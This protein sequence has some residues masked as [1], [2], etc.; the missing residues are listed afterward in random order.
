MK[1]MLF[2]PT[3]AHCLDGY[4][5]AIASVRNHEGRY[6]DFIQKWHG[7]RDKFAKYIVAHRPGSALR[8]H[9]SSHAEQNHASFVQRIGPVCL[10]DPAT[11]IS[12][13]LR[14]HA[15]ICSD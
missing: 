11:A 1:K 6:T 5:T 14:R 9:G 4:T 3:E 2:G 13:I 12:S 10:D 8:R 7:N 15:D